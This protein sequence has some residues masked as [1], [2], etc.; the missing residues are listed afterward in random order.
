MNAYDTRIAVVARE[1]ERC[2]RCDGTLY[3]VYGY[4]LHHR[5]PRGMGG[6]KRNPHINLPSN[7]LA[8]CGSGT[9]GCHGYIEQNRR[10]AYDAGFLVRRPLDPALIPVLGYRGGGTYPVW[11]DDEGH[12]LTTPPEGV[13]MVVETKERLRNVEAGIREIAAQRDHWRDE[14]RTLRDLLGRAVSY[15]PDHLRDEVVGHLVPRG[16]KS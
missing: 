16:D 11:L 15:L 13:E 6:S 2:A 7:F 14:A 5:Q 3:G 9:T 10:W 1:Q 4:S 12:L 8:V